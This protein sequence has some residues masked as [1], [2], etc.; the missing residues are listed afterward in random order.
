M[1][2]AGQGRGTWL[3]SEGTQGRAV[4]PGGQ[5]QAG[6]PSFAGDHLCSSPVL[7][8]CFHMKRPTFLHFSHNPEITCV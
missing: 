6:R 7:S 8:N 3:G 5:L 4:W 1:W 2:G